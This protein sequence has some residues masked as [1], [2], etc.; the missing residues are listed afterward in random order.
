[1]TLFFDPNLNSDSNEVFVNQNEIKHIE[2]VLRKKKGDFLN[3]TNGRGLEALV[4][5]CSNGNDF[6][7]KVKDIIHHTIKDHNTHIALSLCD[8]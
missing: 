6:T 2:K 1:M 4:E 5:I 3:F 7:F 8:G